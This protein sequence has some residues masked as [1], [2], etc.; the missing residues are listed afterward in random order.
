MAEING[1]RELEYIYNNPKAFSESGKNA[2]DTLIN[3][4][5]QSSLDANDKLIRLEE[6]GFSTGDQTHSVYKVGD[7][8]KPVRWENVFITEKGSEYI[9]GNNGGRAGFFKR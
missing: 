6:S 8:P 9:E 3:G 1:H 4:V 7:F 2:I 5:P